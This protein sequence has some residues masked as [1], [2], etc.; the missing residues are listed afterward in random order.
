LHQT[1]LKRA[2]GAEAQ[3]WAWPLALRG[4]THTRNGMIRMHALGDK[5]W[6][7]VGPLAL[8]GKHEA[9]NWMIRIHA[10]LE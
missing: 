6:Y 5:I 1:S 8:R 3:I 7:S 2:I 4:R 9:V 10:I